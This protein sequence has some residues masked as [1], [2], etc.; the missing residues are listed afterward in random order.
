MKVSTE[1]L[2]SR[3]V[4]VDIEVDDER[5]EQA[6][7]QAYRR[8]VGRLKVP[9]FR[10]GKA[11][12][13][14]VERIVG[15]QALLEDAI[16]HLVPVVVKE[17]VEAEG[18]KPA[19]QPRLEVVSIVPLQVKATV[20]LEPRVE[21][22]DYRALLPTPESTEVSEAEVDELVE[23]LREGHAEWVPVERPVRVSDRVALDVRAAVGER[24]LLD[25]KD[26][27]FVVDPNGVQPT[28]GFAEQLVGMEPAEER[29]F[30]LWLPEDYREPELAGQEAT[31]VVK[32]HGVKERHL[33]AADDALASIVG[34]F[35]N[36]EQ[37]RA[38]I[39]R[40]LQVRKEQESQR[41][42]EE[43]AVEAVIAG[44]TVEVPPQVVELEAEHLREQF[45][46]SLDRQGI[47]IEQYLRFAKKNEA[48]FRAELLAEAEKSTRR[49]AVLSAVANAEGIDGSDAEVEEEIRRATEDSPNSQRLVRDAL[50]R[51][52]TRERVRSALRERKAVRRL[53]ALATEASPEPA[54]ARETHGEAH[55]QPV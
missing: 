10:K 6:L 2:E 1:E 33:P 12:R 53:V 22:A 52:E 26:A 48:E 49:S 37:L 43:Q 32:L 47:T 25:T 42:L 19:T 24:V 54:S 27:E 11:P 45:A 5:V 40:D 44:S 4:V 39:A 9:G 34:A 16:E 51:P 28:P 8:V 17:A 30:S 13:G 7:D 3:Q 21:L 55:E 20:A 18:I 46:R 14:L 50:A 38:A 15:R 29:T 31:H 23:R 35:E 36:L 41:K